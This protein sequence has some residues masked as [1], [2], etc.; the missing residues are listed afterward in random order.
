MSDDRRQEHSPGPVPTNRNGAEAA[1]TKMASV[2]KDFLNFF[3]A[4][5]HLVVRLVMRNGANLADAQDATQQAFLQAWRLVKR[6]RWGEIAHQRA[7]IRAV[8]FNHHRAEHRARAQKPLGLDMELPELGPGH[9]DLTGQARDV[10]ALLQRL[11]HDCRAVIAFDLDDIPSSVIAATLLI[12]EQKVRD[13]RKKA[14][15]QLKRHLSAPTHREGRN[16][17]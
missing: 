5:Y 17:Q 2:R 14:R 3:D 10:V 12:T 9:A 6:G 4:E 13:L 16:K 11:D 1:E 8:A 7:W 15:R